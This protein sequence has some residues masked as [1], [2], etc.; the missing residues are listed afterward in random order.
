MEAL[1]QFSGRL[2][3]NIILDKVNYVCA[4]LEGQIVNGLESKFHIATPKI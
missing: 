4:L 2:L 3:P 1:Q